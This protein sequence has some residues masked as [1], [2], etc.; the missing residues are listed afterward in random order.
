ML[1]FVVEEQGC[2][3][4]YSE[5]IKREINQYSK[6]NY[7]FIVYIHLSPKMTSALNKESSNRSSHIV[8][9]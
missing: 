5:F 2:I 1:A 6:S 7:I 9:V 8:K 4:I 3:V